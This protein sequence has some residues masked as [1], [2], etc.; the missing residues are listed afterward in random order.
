MSAR[1]AAD[2]LVVAHLGFILFVVAGGLAVLRWPRM[3]WLHLPAV[4]WGAWI[5]LSAGTCPLTPLENRWR[6]AA[7]EGAWEGDFVARYLLP[8]IYPR[9]LTRNAQLALGVGV[10]VLN[11][12]V[13]ALIVARQRRRRSERP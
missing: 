4:A 3:A 1:L 9:G 8:L 10:L 6:T 2:L 7:G 5:E 11:L 12:A 13:Y